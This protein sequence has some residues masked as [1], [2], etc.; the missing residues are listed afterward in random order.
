MDKITNEKNTFTPN[1]VIESLT[2]KGVDISTIKIT[3]ELIREN[4]IDKYRYSM[5]GKSHK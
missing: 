2:K 5:H 4:N 1:D 3:E